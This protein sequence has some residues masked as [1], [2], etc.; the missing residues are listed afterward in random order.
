MLSY[1]SSIFVPH[2]SACWIRCQKTG[3]GIIV[4]CSYFVFFLFLSQKMLLHFHCCLSHIRTPKHAMNETETDQWT[5]QF[6][7]ITVTPVAPGHLGHVLML[8]PG[9]LIAGQLLCK[10]CWMCISIV[11]SKGL[12]SSHLALIHNVH[13]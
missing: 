4:S 3:F 13:C 2:Y 7:S 10:E 1:A 12:P 6:A 11:W 5:D 8:Q 9:P